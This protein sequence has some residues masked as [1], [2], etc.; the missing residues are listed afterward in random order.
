M[1]GR[2]II[3][4]GGNAGIGL[5]TSIALAKQGANI[6][7]VSRSKDKAEEAVKKIIAES[8]NKYVTYF[9][10]NL[11]SQKSIRQLASEIKNQLL[12][13]ECFLLLRYERVSILIYG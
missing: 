5:A 10:A 2:N 9:V 12:Y 4:T 3:I 13:Q 8:G 6:Y 11:S 1:K 7:I